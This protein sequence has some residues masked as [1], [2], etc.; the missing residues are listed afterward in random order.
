[1]S[2]TT[3]VTRTEY[4]RT[5]RAAARLNDANLRRYDLLIEVESKPQTAGRARFAASLRAEIDR[6]TVAYDA[7][8]LGFV[9]KVQAAGSEAVKTRLEQLLTSHGASNHTMAVAWQFVQCPETAQP[10]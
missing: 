7:T 9:R 5:A 2:N 1:M 8:I 3:A 6:D 10:R 4:T